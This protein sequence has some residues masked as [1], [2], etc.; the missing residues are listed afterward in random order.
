MIGPFCEHTVRERRL[1]EL[2]DRVQLT[3]APCLMTCALRGKK[4]AHSPNG[5]FS[6]FQPSL[7]LYFVVAPEHGGITSRNYK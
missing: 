6:F 2:S 1:R 5:F 4:G 3:R 7:S